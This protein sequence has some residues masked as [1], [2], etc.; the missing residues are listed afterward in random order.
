MSKASGESTPTVSRVE[1]VSID[2]LFN[3]VKA[4]F[5]EM[6]RDNEVKFNE[7]KSRFDIN[8]Q[9]L[10]RQNEKFNELSSSVNQINIKLNEQKIKCESSFNELSKRFD[11]NEVKLE[12]KFEELRNDIKMCI[13]DR[14]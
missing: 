3:F 4:N 6:K 7:V 11:M 14:D 5:H 2:D 1:K 10:D 13:R 9:K 12:S 8:D